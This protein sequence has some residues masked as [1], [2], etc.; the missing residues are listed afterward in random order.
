MIEKIKNI[1]SKLKSKFYYNYE[2][3]K[4]T[5]F[6]AG[7]KT[8]VFVVVED[9][10]ELDII[11]H[12][13]DDL[14]YYVIGAGSNLLVRDKGFD[15]VL[16]KLG[17]G[18][19]EIKLNRDKLIVGA[20][21]L[22]VNLANFAKKNLISGFEFFIGVP[23]TIGGAIK[24]NAGCFGSKTSDILNNINITDSLG[25]KKKISMKELNMKYRSSNV[26]DTNIITSAEFNISYGIKKEIDEKI[27]FIKN[28]RLKK[29][30]IREKTSGST[31]KNPSNY[32]AAKLIEES[33][34]KGLKVG[35]AVVSN[36][37]C[38]FLINKGNAS[39]QNLED[40]GKKIIEKVFN[41]FDIK[42]EW[43]I[44]IIGN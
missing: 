2:M 36:Q 23:G 16:I 10:Y 35:D 3:E 40:L 15:G 17:K 30:P 5:W 42:L 11:M 27:K 1:E 20:S 22:D 26:L 9:P 28:E 29:Q 21:I 37:H 8:K 14:Q 19:N 13:I 6:R 4:I 43:E 44:K 18:F 7:G 25:T 34:C 38:N 24:M 12:A 41:K 32:F 31:F 33:G 39:A